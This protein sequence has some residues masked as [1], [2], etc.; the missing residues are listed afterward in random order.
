MVDILIRD[1][2]YVI[3]MDK[4]RRV[5]KDGLIAIEGNKIL[6]VGK[7]VDLARKYS[8]ETVIDAKQKLL[9]PGF[10]NVHTHAGSAIN[11][12][13]CDDVPNVLATIFLP[14]AGQQTKEDRRRIARAGLLDDVRFGTTCIGDDLTLAEDVAE[15]GLR[16]VLNLY[17][18]DADTTSYDYAHHLKYSYRPEI[19]ELL[20]R[21]GLDE[22]EKWDG[23]ADGR[24]SCALGPH[25][26]DY[27]SRQLLEEMRELA[28]KRKKR[29]TIHLAQNYM[30]IHQ[31]RSLYGKTPVEFL[32]DIDFLGPDVY[33][34]HCIYATMNDIKILKNS[35]TKIC[36]SPLNL[37]RLQSVVAPV[38]E[39]IDLGMTVGICTDGAG[40]GDMLESARAALTLQRVRAGQGYHQYPICGAAPP[41]PMKILEMMTIDAAKVLGLDNEI[42]SLGPGKKADVVLLNARTPHL[43]PMINPVG[44]IIHYAFGSDVDTS[45]VD[46]KVIME[47]RVVGTVDEEEVLEQAQ[48][49]GER[50]YAKFQ[51]KFRDHIEAYGIY[52]ALEY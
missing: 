46:G 18:R 34:A 33:A 40:S 24:I 19:G 37:A 38:L 7:T 43:T 15:M 49:A 14:L 28:N 39:W 16:G 17:V 35:D 30:E 22:M 26:P 20:L 8:A 10:I 47:N 31:V 29:L 3:T 21:E 23:K 41:S 2:K 4:D 27:C 13:V 51:G 42:G 11:R 44:S 52:K 25:G 9:L 12:G 50:T 36:H 45:I 1:A 48:E 5:I 6:D 32:R